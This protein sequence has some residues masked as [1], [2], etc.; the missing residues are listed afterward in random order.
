MLTTQQVYS[1]KGL[2][3]LLDYIASLSNHTHPIV[4][5]LDDENIPKRC[6]KLFC[7]DKT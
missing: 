7:C 5:I 2:I 6:V 1:Y 4:P 3:E